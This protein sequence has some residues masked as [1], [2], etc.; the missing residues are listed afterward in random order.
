MLA[1][2]AGV[3]IIPMVEVTIYSE[4]PLRLAASSRRSSRHPLGRRAFL[5]RAAAP[6]S[7]AATRHFTAD[8]PKGETLAPIIL[9]TGMAD[10][11]RVTA[12]AAKRF[13]LNLFDI[14]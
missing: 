8:M 10:P 12:A 4:N 14:A 2:E 11:H 7:T 3:V 9:V 13:C 1:V 6:S 5:T